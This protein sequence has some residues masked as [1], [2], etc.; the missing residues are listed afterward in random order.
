MPQQ[1]YCG[2]LHELYYVGEL[3]AHFS[4]INSNRY[5]QPM[6]GQGLGSDRAN[7]LKFKH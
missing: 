3:L 4:A 2:T 1:L 7:S 6:S 5:Y